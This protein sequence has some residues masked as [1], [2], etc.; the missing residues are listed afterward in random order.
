MLADAAIVANGKLYVHGG[1]WNFL[2]I[3]DPDSYRPITIVGRVVVPWSEA[4]ME[5]S[6]DVRLEYRDGEVI[7]EDAPLMQIA[8][9]PQVKP[10]QP[11][12]LETATPIVLDIPGIGF[13]EPGE[14]AF[15]IKH[16]DKELART[17]L[18][19][20]FFSDTHRSSEGYAEA[21]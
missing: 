1:G 10:D 6:L 5:I 16:G 7:L 17:R 12:A 11:K 18:Q 13:R 20:N 9:Q 21:S 15:V 2:D 8:M 4:D 14:Y 19:V 3:H